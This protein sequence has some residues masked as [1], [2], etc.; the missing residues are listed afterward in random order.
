MPDVFLFA[1]LAALGV[2]IED[3]IEAVTNRLAARLIVATC[4]RVVTVAISAAR[5]RT[6]P[7]RKRKARTPKLKT[8]RSK[9]PTPR[10][11]LWREH[12]PIVL[13]EFAHGAIKA[14][15]DSFR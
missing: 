11:P 4:E 15:L 7:P 5:K 1:E 2:R 8:S 9:K 10:D 6:A 13:R 3:L 12:V 14:L